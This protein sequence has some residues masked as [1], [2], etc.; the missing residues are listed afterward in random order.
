[1][2]KKSIYFDGFCL[3]QEDVFFN[4]KC[5]NKVPYLSKNKTSNMNIHIGTFRIRIFGGGT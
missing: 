5:K 4:K 3:S 1:V 2:E